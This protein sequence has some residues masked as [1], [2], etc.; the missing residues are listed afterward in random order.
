MTM[1]SISYKYILV[2]N[3][4]NGKQSLV[5]NN[6]DKIENIVMI[7]ISHSCTHFSHHDSRLKFF[8]NSAVC[9]LNYFI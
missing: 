9:G 4:G 6:I 8:L 3:E 2:L 1:N 7:M 5:N